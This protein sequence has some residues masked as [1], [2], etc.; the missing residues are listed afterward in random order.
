MRQVLKD[1]KK[2]EALAAL[3]ERLEEIISSAVTQGEQAIDISL[4][5]MST[6]DII[7]ED[8][9]HDRQ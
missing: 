8:Q 5:T 3:A 7:P 9:N 4:K 6:L 1:A 2:V